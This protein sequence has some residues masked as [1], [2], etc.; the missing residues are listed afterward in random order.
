MSRSVQ[1]QVLANQWNLQ[2][3]NDC[4]RVCKGPENLGPHSHQTIA[5]A[6][7]GV[8]L[9]YNVNA[10]LALH[11]AAAGAQSLDRGPH[12]HSGQCESADQTEF[13]PGDRGPAAMLYL[14]ERTLQTL[15][16]TVRRK[17]ILLTI[18]SK[19]LQTT[20]FD[21]AWSFLL[22][23]KPGRRSQSNFAGCCQAY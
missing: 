19:R 4:L 14:R 20:C 6:H 17:L 12:D 23:F 7:L 11:D 18:L 21:L 1:V 16:D 13:L 22:C 5:A 2:G 8:C 3:K 9:A 10:P 15:L